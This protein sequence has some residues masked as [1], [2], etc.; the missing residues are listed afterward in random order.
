MTTTSNVLDATANTASTKPT[1]FSALSSEQ[2][3]KI[4]LTELGNQ[5]PLSPSDTNALLQQLSSI[6]NIQSSM[7]LSEKLG[8]LVSDNQFSSAS[9]MIGKI[10]GG[11]STDNTRSMGKVS[12][13]SKTDDGV[14]L[15]LNTGKSIKLDNMDGVIDPASL[16]DDE[17][18]LL[19]LT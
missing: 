3:T 16:T 14:F 1:G 11:V 13:I 19:G 4:I 10:V 2:F 8:S 7:D 12:S 17:K 9:N 18:A 6:R 5:D 15:N